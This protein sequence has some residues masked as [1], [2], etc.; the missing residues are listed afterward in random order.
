MSSVPPWGVPFHGLIKGSE[1]TLPNGQTIPCRQPSGFDFE[2]GHTHLIEVPGTPEVVRT[3]E[4]AAED[5]A[6]GRQWLNKAMI[7]GN[8]IHG[9]TIGNGGMLYIAPDGGR[10]LVSSSLHGSNSSVA[11]FTVTLSLF[12]ILGGDSEQYSYTVSAPD[13]SAECAYHGISES[14]GRVRMYHAHPQG[15]AAVYGVFAQLSVYKEFAALAWLEISLSGPA[16]NCIINCS[17]IRDAATTDGEAIQD[18]D[19]A[20]VSE[21]TSYIFGSNSEADTTVDAHPDCSGSYRREITYSVSTSAS[22]QEASVQ[23]LPGNPAEGVQEHAQNYRD[24]IVGMLY[25][26][27][28]NLQE[29]TLETL[30][31]RTITAGP[32][33]SSSTPYILAYNI[34]TGAGVCEQQITQEQRGSVTVGQTASFDTMAT[35]VV[36]IGAQEITRQT[37][38]YTRSASTTYE[39]TRG[40][41][42]EG[43]TREGLL[44]TSHQCLPGGTGTSDL[45]TNS[46]WL[47]LAANGGRVTIDPRVYALEMTSGGWWFNSDRVASSFSPAQDSLSI[48]L[49]RLSNG[50]YGFVAR[51]RNL[52]NNLYF[53]THMNEGGT[54]QGPVVLEEISTSSSSAYQTNATAHGSYNPITGQAAQSFSSVC[55][56]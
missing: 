49:I 24:I 23:S 35:F 48:R 53:Y 44:S 15:Q 33:T 1:L 40:I 16:D 39:Y 25:S 12:G 52:G 21:F 8:Q 47:G 28:G 4:E 17:L 3:S 55:W 7:S 29:V 38:S 36:R 37:M 50:L 2:R 54:P 41:S 34:V 14:S 32:I 26:E 20:N 9:V 45:T 22:G 46:G 30:L 31:Q 51:R 18:D 5:T 56:T 27:A 43:I 19:F 13:L 42:G 11:V 10:W 6:S